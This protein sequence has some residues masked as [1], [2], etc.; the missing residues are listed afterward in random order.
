MT[1]RVRASFLM[2]TAAAMAMMGLTGCDHYVCGSGAI[3]GGTC[4]AGSSS[5]GTTTSGS[6]TAAFV[7]VADA[8][9]ATSNGTIDGYT[10]NT[11]ASTFGPTSTYTAPA[12]P[13]NDGGVGMVVAQATYLYTGFGTTSTIYGWSIGSAGTLTALSGSPYAAP[14]MPYVPTGFGTQSI[15]TNPAGTLLFFSAAA[16]GTGTNGPQV[17][18]YQ[19]GSGGALTAATGSP[20]AVPFTGNLAT[21]GLGKYLYITDAAGN[22]T[23][24]EIAAY[25]IASTGAL[26]MVA[27]SPFA[28]SNFNMWQI[29][30]EPTGKYMIGTTGQSVAIN[31]VD[32][33]AL[34]VF[35]IGTTGAL[36]EVSGSPFVTQSSPL[37]IA[38]QS[39]ANGSLIY[40]F[41]LTDD[42]SAFNSVEGYTISSSGT[43]TA[44]TDSP[45]SNAAVGDQGAFDQSGAFLFVYG[46]VDNL[47]TNTI[48]PQMGAFAVASNGDLTEPTTTLTLTSPGFFAVTDPQ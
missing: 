36:A 13:L 35:S 29:Q 9:G 21:D 4:T 1:M 8:T 16:T 42:R 30:G 2:I 3:L 26:T 33:D 6:A 22:H 41:G 18:V 23:G 12:T 14:F 37:S 28:G 39:D 25:S 27:G 47:S 46:V 24:S 20:F 31:A 44:V 45:F 48:S 38:V 40:T 7:F 17:F 5:L 43:L 11:S 10:L 15:I 32:N 34:Y 19:I